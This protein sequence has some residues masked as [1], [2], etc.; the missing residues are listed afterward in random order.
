MSIYDVDYDD[1]SRQVLPPDKRKKPNRDFINALLYPLQYIHNLTMTDYRVGSTAIPWLDSTTYSEGDR[2]VYKGSAYESKVNANINNLPTDST[3]WN[4]V[5]ENFIG[6]FERVKYNG[7]K[8]TFEWAINK[9]F[10][11]Y[12]AIFRQ[13]PNVSDIY[14]VAHEKPPLVFISGATEAFSSNVYLDRSTEFVVN[15]YT[16]GSYFNCSIMVPQAIYDQLDTDPN[17]RENIIRL[18]ADQYIVA[19]VLYNVVTY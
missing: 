10:K 5:Q 15:D 16:F 7:N 11:E 19:G 1:Y 3:W 8:L 9:F 13:P 17:N 6:V 12:G 4:K 18:F 2:V 14:L